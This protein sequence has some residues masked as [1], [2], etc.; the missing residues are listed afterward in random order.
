MRWHPF[1][2]SVV[3][4]MA[5]G[6]KDGAP[7]N[8]ASGE[9]ARVASAVT[10]TCGNGLVEEGELCD[11][12]AQV[13]CGSLSALYTAGKTVCASNCQGYE[14]ARD[15]TRKTGIIS[16]TI[17]PALRNASRWGDAKCNDGSS[18][19]FKFSPSPTGSKVWIINTEG[20]GYCDGYTNICADRGSWLSSNSLDPD[21]TLS[22][23][24]AGGSNILSRDPNENPTFANANQA[25][26]HYC[27]SDLWSGTNTVPQPVDNGL[28][29]LFSGRLN[30]RAMLEILRRDY[31]LDDRDPTLKI[32]WTGQSAGGQGAQN[33]ADQLARAMPKARADRRLWIISS[34]GW[35][36]LNWNNPSYT[37]GGKGDPDTVVSERLSTLYKA[38]FSP[39]CR[40][41]AQ[42]NG[43][44]ASACFSG[45]AAMAA[46][47]LPQ[48]RGGLGLR[49][50]AATN[51]RDAV[52]TSH[53]GLTDSSAQTHAALQQWDDLMAK[54]MRDSGIRWLFAPSDD[55]RMGTKLHGIYDWWQVPFKGY[56][57][58]NDVCDDPYTAADYRGMVTRFFEDTAPDT[59]HLRVCFNGEWLP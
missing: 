34:A 15:C 30:A 24:S 54:E 2:V 1:V 50:M 51:R 47:H 7:E 56:D 43:R 19:T 59:S 36:P 27:S 45:M 58:A 28:K 10:A 44:P 55:P 16:E 22:A 6:G 21:R 40:A 25:S 17:R 12:T 53:H 37:Q 11:G 52:Y 38:E 46:I 8:E 48:S 42:A 4:M 26:G 5:C 14:V 32:I 57:A 13:T 35:M 41:L 20:G 9:L 18:F 3:V 33:N 29:L 23:T 49:L 39:E 31:G